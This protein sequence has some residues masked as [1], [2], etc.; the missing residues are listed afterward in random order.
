M[1]ILIQRMKIL[2]LKLE[3]KQVVVE[4]KIHRIIN[5]NYNNNKMTTNKEDAVELIIYI[6]SI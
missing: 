2:G 4:V 5:N 6:Y 3:L 1:E